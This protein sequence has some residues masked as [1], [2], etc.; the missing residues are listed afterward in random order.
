MMAGAPRPLL[1]T[2]IKEK[3]PRLN[4]GA[5]FR[6]AVAIGLERM[7]ARGQTRRFDPLPA[8]SGLP[9]TTDISR[10]ARLVRLVPSR[11]WPA[12]FND[13]VGSQQE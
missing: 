8:T 7:S 1:K 11:K 3:R 6:K 5:F 2:A 10:P 12:L 9:R 4:A 13:L